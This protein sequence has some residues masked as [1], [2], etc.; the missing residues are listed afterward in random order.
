MLS[1]FYLVLGCL[2]NKQ[3]SF[4][5][6]LG[7]ENPVLF[8][9]SNL[10]N[11]DVILQEL[12][13]YSI[14]KHPVTDFNAIRSCLSRLYAHLYPETWTEVFYTRLQNFVKFHHDC[15]PYLRL[16][17]TDET[18]SYQFFEDK[19]II[20][21]AASVKTLNPLLTVRFPKKSNQ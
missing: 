17:A 19:T 16:T 20:V 6:C 2:G 8:Y 21:S 7:L 11:K 13:T 9:S 15:S 4:V 1:Q 5:H 10:P 14:L 3:D 18:F 12:K